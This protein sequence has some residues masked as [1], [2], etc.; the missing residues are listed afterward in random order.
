MSLIHTQLALLQHHITNQ[1][2]MIEAK[3]DGLL[4]SVIE[5]EKALDRIE[6]QYL[7]NA[8]M[9]DKSLAD[10]LRLQL[11][12]A[13]T[14]LEVG[15][16][17][18]LSLESQAVRYIGRVDIDPPVLNEFLEATRVFALRMDDYQQLLARAN[19]STNR[20]LAAIVKE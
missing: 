14:L 9:G 18:K 5:R 7:I 4:P 10:E 20:M 1:T 12:A 17:L 3:I 16:T 19:R 2:V 13:E 6:G 11:T 8:M 15:L